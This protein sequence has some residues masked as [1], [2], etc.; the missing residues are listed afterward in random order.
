[1]KKFFSIFSVMAVVIAAI[2]FVSC[3]KDNNDPVIDEPK[4]EIVKAAKY[5]LI[6]NEDF[7]K[8]GDVE[9][10]VTTDGMQEVY[11]FFQVAK[12]ETLDL[13][14]PGISLK[15]API[16]KIDTK[17]EYKKNFKISAKF[18]LTDEGK[19]LVEAASETDDFYFYAEDSF[20]G[21]MRTLSN[22][23]VY[24]KNLVEYLTI[25]NEYTSHSAL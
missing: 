17:F 22:M 14:F 7:F 10:T 9:V 5:Y 21:H 6:V 23:S 15:N 16:R 3:S 19:K 20:D 8:Y 13:D 11:S 1:M 2:S 25:M 4:P 24:V 18:I 12:K